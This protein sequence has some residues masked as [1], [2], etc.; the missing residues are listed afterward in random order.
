MPEGLVELTDA[1][2]GEKIAKGVTLVDFYGSWCPPCR[3]L[4]PELEKLAAGYAGRAKIARINVDD[5][6][7]SAVD[8]LVEEIPTLIFFK[9]GEEKKRLFGAQSGEILAEAL[10]SLLS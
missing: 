1:D 6:S 9:D 7:E 10:D 8:N 2:F 4:E 5:N 3:Q